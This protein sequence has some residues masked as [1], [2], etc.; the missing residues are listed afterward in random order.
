MPKQHTDIIYDT[1]IYVLYMCNHVGYLIVIYFRMQ[2][3]L[4]SDEWVKR[5]AQAWE[6]QLW[7]VPSIT[8]LRTC[9]YIVKMVPK[10]VTI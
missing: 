6:K 1:H 2:V 4:T 5:E 3:N 9:T 10:I 8:C 7:G